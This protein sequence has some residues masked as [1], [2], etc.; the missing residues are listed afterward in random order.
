MKTNF[1]T[2]CLYS[3]GLVWNKQKRLYRSSIPL[4]VYCLGSIYVYCVAKVFSVSPAGLVVRCECVSLHTLWSVDQLDSCAPVPL[5]SW[6]RRV[7]EYLRSFHL[8][9]ESLY[10]NKH[11]RYRFFLYCWWSWLCWNFTVF[12]HPSEQILGFVSCW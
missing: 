6:I 8:Y 3:L 7:L 12:Y 9:I 2:Q 1:V 4:A 11:N 10:M 5:P